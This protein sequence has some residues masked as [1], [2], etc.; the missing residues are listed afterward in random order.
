MPVE[1]EAQKGDMV[2]SIFAKC[3]V[4]Q[5]SKYIGPTVQD[6]TEHVVAHDIHIA[7]FSLQHSSRN[8]L[9][10]EVIT[11][12]PSLELALFC[13]VCHDL[14]CTCDTKITAGEKQA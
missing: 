2:M 7:W 1:E 4:G 14:I 8:L 3:P 10:G 6:F 5:C 13:D 12:L 11:K 9:L